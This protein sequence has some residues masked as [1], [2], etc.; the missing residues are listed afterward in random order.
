M[1]AA[2][3]GHTDTVKLLLE[4]GADVNA[5]NQDGKN[6][7]RIAADNWHI[8]VVKLIQATGYDPKKEK[9]KKE[10][11]KRY[12]EFTPDAFVQAAGE[13]D[14]EI[15]ELFLEAGM[16]VDIVGSSGGYYSLG[17]EGT[18][19]MHARREGQ[20][21]IAKLLLEHGADPNQTDD[22]T[23]ILIEAVETGNAD[24][25]RL[26]LE[27]GADPDAKDESDW[28]RG[29]TALIVAC[30]YDFPELVQALIDAGANVNE[31]ETGKTVPLLTGTM[32]RKLWDITEAQPCS[33]P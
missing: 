2:M 9:I 14:K 29:Q 26:L 7:F 28:Q 17:A 31:K 30:D 6:A 19:L 16:E 18:A 4:N 22:E 3:E 12:I 32:D 8:D 5:V 33:E 27:Y 25:A 23:P 10:L 13:G 24:I 21:E 1:W 11:E 20:T 15:V